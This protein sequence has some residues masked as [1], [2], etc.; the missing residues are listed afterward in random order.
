MGFFF[1][2]LLNSVLFTALGIAKCHARRKFLVLN[3]TKTKKQNKH[4]KTK[5]KTNN[6]IIRKGEEAK[7]GGGRRRRERA[8]L[9]S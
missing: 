9:F 2:F 7:A 4:R 3:Q 1:F 5:M 6:A 8:P